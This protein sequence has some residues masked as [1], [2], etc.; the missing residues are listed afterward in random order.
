MSTAKGR[1]AEDAAAKFLQKQGY[2]ILDR[3][4]R[5]GR[6]ELDIVATLDDILIFVEVKGHQH[7]T[8]SLEAMHQSKQQRLISAAQTWLGLHAEYMHHQCRFDLIMVTPSHMKFFPPKIEYMQDI[9][10]L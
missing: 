9:I 3:N 10:R 7:R 5:L 6:G 1:V 8:S 4:R 2:T